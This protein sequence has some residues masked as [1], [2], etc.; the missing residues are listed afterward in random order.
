MKFDLKMITQLIASSLSCAD[1]LQHALVFSQYQREIAS[2]ESEMA[3]L[4]QSAHLFDVTVS[5]YRQLKCCRKEIVL[6]KSL[7]D[8][9]GA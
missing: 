6:L 1:C 2:L 4:L 5:E 3:L 9:V 8:S 7:W